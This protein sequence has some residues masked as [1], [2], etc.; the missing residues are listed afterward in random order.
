MR[1][2]WILCLTSALSA[3][4]AE[5]PV[6][7]TPVEQLQQDALSYV[8]AQAGTLAGHYTFHVLKPPSV[9]RVLAGAKL[10]FEPANL[11][12]RDLGGVFFVSFKMKLDGRPAGMLRVDM[13]GK[14]TGMVLRAK[15]PLQRKTIPAADAFE[16]EPFEG[17]PPPGAL[18]EV[19]AGYRLRL[20][21]AAGHLLTMVDL[22]SIPVVTAGDQVRVELVSGALVI[23]VDAVA[24][25]NG[26][27]GEKVRLEMPTSHKNLQAVV[28]GPGEARL[29]WAG[30]N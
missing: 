28:T 3:A 11:S 18:S 24:R 2:L 14:W 12:R 17:N 10:T 29:L 15:A 30:G 21:V 5:D 25:S 1:W 19:P 9:P 6:P 27:V 16:V 7:L 4:G 22:E 20:P 8:Q 23:A 26:A 13:E